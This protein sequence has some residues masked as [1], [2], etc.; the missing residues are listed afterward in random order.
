M[1][2]GQ[3]HTHCGQANPGIPH[4]WCSEIKQTHTISYINLT[5]CI[6]LFFVHNKQL[7]HKV[8]RPKEKKLTKFVF[9]KIS[10]SIWYFLSVCMYCGLFMDEQK[11]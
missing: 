5:L 8:N 3:K 7:I 10:Y 4:E 6:Y 11:E 2:N 1:Y 9:V